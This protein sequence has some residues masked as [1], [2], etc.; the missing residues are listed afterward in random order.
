MSSWVE[1]DD[2]VLESMTP[3]EWGRRERFPAGCTFALEATNWSTG[4]AQTTRSQD[5]VVHGVETRGI[6]PLTST[7]QRWRS[8]N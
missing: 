3:A 7:L 4:K 5:L 6:E 2:A 8:A 1:P